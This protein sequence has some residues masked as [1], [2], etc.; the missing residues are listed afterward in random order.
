MLTGEPTAPEQ[1]G[2]RVPTAAISLAHVERAKPAVGACFSSQPGLEAR[3][4]WE[5][6]A[7]W[8]SDRKQMTDLEKG[9]KK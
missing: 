4:G 6:K 1:Q 8:C 3:Q 5:R 2:Q 9:K 7:L